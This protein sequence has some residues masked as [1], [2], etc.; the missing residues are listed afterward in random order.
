MNLYTY[1][2]SSAS[3]QV[4]IALHL[5]NL[6]FTSIPIHLLKE[7]QN[8]HDY[9]VKN[10]QGFVPALEVGEQ[11]LTQ[12]MAILEYLEE[13]HPNP[14]LLP[15][16]PLVRAKVRSLCQMI[17]CDVHPLN[18]RKVLKYLSQQLS[19]NDEQKQ[20]WYAH[21][22]H[23]IFVPLEM[24]LKN[25]SGTFC[26]GDT[27]TLADCFLI[28]QVSNARRYDVNLLDYPTIVA[29]DEHCA[30]LAAFIKAHPKNQADCDA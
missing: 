21:W 11:V 16:N 6:D 18:S 20:A 19:L 12:S 29:I 28:P 17:A 15:D 24:M 22:V 26:F 14:L 10:P 27:L 9:L 25:T 2:R 13:T 30:T 5:K 4:R 3:Y 1:F 7:Q 23:E 8:S